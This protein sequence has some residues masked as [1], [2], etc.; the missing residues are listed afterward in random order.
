[1]GRSISDKEILQDCL[2]RNTEQTKSKQSPTPGKLPRLTRPAIQNPLLANYGNRLNNQNLFSLLP[3][4]VTTPSQKVG[5]QQLNQLAQTTIEQT[6]AP[7]T[8]ITP[9]P[10]GGMAQAQE[11]ISMIEDMNIGGE[12]LEE[13]SNVREEL[14]EKSTEP[15][16]ENI[17]TTPFR[18]NIEEQD[19][20]EDPFADLDQPSEQTDFTEISLRG[21]QKDTRSLSFQP[22]EPVEPPP[23]DDEEPGT[24]DAETTSNIMSVGVFDEEEV[25]LDEGADYP[26]SI[27]PVEKLVD[28]KSISIPKQQRKKMK[29]KVN[30]KFGDKL[31]ED[32]TKYLTRPGTRKQAGRKGKEERYLEALQIAEEQKGRRLREPELPGVYKQIYDDTG[33]GKFINQ[34]RNEGIIEIIEGQEEGELR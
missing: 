20:D 8:P 24:T 10:Q 26:K 32:Q 7:V 31:S 5:V 25:D 30:I 14:E 12:E 13:K 34:M 2:K 15:A 9:Q 22:P 6:T 27:Q 29:N 19:P 11:V 18:T 16:Q 23:E 28:Y 4:E 33:F 17:V 3:T 1:M 21:L